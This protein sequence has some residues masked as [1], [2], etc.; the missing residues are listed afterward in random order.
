MVGPITNQVPFVGPLRPDGGAREQ[1][2]RRIQQEQSKYV[3]PPKDENGSQTENDE[4]LTA[5]NEIA[6]LAKGVTSA[7]GRLSIDEDEGSGDFIYRVID[8]STG[9]VINQWPREELLKH[10][11]LAKSHYE[12]VVYDIEV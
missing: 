4:I 1:E 2:E 3:A 7:S 8:A 5:E 11:R 10:A 9:E 6:K 12:G